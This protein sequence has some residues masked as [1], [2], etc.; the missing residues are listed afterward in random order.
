MKRSAVILVAAALVAAAVIVIALTLRPGP[1]L[2]VYASADDVYARPVIAAFEKESGLRVGLVTDAEAAKTTGLYQRLLAER[3]RPRADVFWNNEISRTLLLARAGL[4][5]APS[6]PA[7]PVREFR[8]ARGLW[9]GLA[10]RARVL[11]YN[12][13][14]VAEAEAPAS[15]FDLASPRWKGQA[16]VAYPLFGTTATHFAALRAHPRLGRERATEFFRGLLAND[17]QVVDGNAVAA[18]LV[19]EGRALVALTD[20]DDAWAQVDAG[21]PV[22]IVYPDQEENGLGTLVIPNTVSQ[23]A[24]APH[25]EAAARFLAFMLSA[26]AEAELAKPPARHLPTLTDVPAAPDATPLYMIRRM[27]IDWEKVADEIDAQPADLEALFR[28]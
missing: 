7:G 22:R 26:R 12:T 15:V 8:D 5:A 11:V 3:A 25:P 14:K 19:G 17:V 21:K 20:T 10:C 16:A 2:V 6:L 9:Q 23:L 28:R 4:L 18:R 27:E 1:D 24:G 13:A